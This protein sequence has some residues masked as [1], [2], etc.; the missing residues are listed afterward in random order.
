[1]P[2]RPQSAAQTAPGRGPAASGPGGPGGVASGALGK[3]PRPPPRGQSSVRRVSVVGDSAIGDSAI[4]DSAIGDGQRDEE[5]T[6]L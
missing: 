2:A 5:R 4:G 1:M 6:E 3:S